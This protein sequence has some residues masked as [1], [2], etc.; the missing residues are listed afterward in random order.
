M[1]IEARD[2]PSAEQQ[3]TAPQAAAVVTQRRH[4]RGRG[5]RSRRGYFALPGAGY[6][7]LF[8]IYPLYQ[9]VAMSL[10]DVTSAN[11]LGTWE[12]NN[13]ENFAATARDSGFSASVTNTLILVACLLLI[14]LGGGMVAALVLQRNTFLTSLT[15]GFMIFVWALPPVVSGN[16]WKF[17][18]S[19]DGVVNSVLLGLGAVDSPVLW[20]VDERL[21]LMSVVLI[22]AW[23][24]LPFATLVIRAALLD[25]SQDLLEAA[26]I[27]GAGSFKRFRYITIPHIQPTLWVLA[28]LLVVSAFRS[29]DLIYVTTAGGPG[30]ATHTLPFLAYRQAFR[31][32]Q[33]GLGAATSVLALCI[34]LGLA[35]VYGWIQREENR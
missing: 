24:I 22:S 11:V 18:L 4:R 20:L 1:T 34:V 15:L 7:I 13:Y 5:R 12:W 17:L 35:L 9:L 23:T 19:A 31:T 6:L 8:A 16:L 33:F 3:Y 30:T 21:S 26:A 14:G 28:V 27:D 10:T 32:F 25:V 2:F 29:F